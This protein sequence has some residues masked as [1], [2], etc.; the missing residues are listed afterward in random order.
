MPLRDAGAGDGGA[1]RWWPVGAMGVQVFDRWWGCYSTESNT[2]PALQA[3]VR[4]DFARGR[5]ATTTP[6]PTST[7]S[8][9]TGT[10]ALTDFASIGTAHTPSQE[11]SGEERP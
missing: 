11:Q 2:L 9:I 1:G 3:G 7:R 4:T 5:A 10:A 6:T 8:I